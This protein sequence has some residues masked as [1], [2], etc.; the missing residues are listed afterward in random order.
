[1]GSPQAQPFDE[2]MQEQ[3]RREDMDFINECR[4][5]AATQNAQYNQTLERYR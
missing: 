3:L 2:S 5:Q 4:W 1:M